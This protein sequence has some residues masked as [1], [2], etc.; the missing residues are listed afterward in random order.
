MGDSPE[1]VGDERLVDDLVGPPPRP[2]L[3][4][5]EPQALAHPPE[6]EARL[7][8]D[9]HREV[10][11][12]VRHALHVDELPDE[13]ADRDVG[14]FGRSRTT[15]DDEHVAIDFSR[16][17][18]LMHLCPTRH[19]SRDEMPSD[20]RG[21]ATPSSWQIQAP[22]TSS[23]RRPLTKDGS[24]SSTGTPS[25]DLN[26]PARLELRETLLGGCQEEVADL[27]EERR[28]SS[29]KK[30]ALA[31][32]KRTSG[33]LENC[34]RTPP[35][36]F[37]WHRTTSARSQEN[38]V[39]R[40]TLIRWYAIDAPIAPA[41]ATTIRATAPA[42]RAPRDRASAAARARPGERAVREGRG[43]S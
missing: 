3:D 29:A 35:I 40:P 34:C 26:G 10:R 24:T 6:V 18:V 39:V 5:R 4:H 13:R 19:G 27:L 20:P 32:A 25:L 41:P 17:S 33:S 12:Q 23:T 38:N 14:E 9:R 15:G 8:L 11:R 16:V 31:C 28:A 30:R 21:S 2:R 22:R 37:P 36:A 42:R 43:R 7:V 1:P